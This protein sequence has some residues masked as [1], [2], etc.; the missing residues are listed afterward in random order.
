MRVIDRPLYMKKVLPMIDTEFIKIITGVRRSGKS[1]LL[2][3]IR[4]ELL[5]RSVNPKQIIYINFEN[6]EFF[7]LLN[8][9]DLYQ[10][11]KGKVNK[12]QKVYFLFDEIQE[13]TGWQ[14][15]VNGLRVAYDSDIY[16]TGSNASILSGELATYLTGRYVEI[17]VQPLTF[18]EYLHFKGKEKDHAERYFDDYLEYGGFPAVA[19]QTNDQ[20]KNDALNGI[21]NSILLRDVTQRT[22]VKNPE[23]LERI[24]LF[25]L[26]NIGQLVNVNKIANTLRSSGLRV[27]NNTIENYM[28]LLEDA[29]LFYKVSRYDIRG[30]EYLRGQ[31]KYY[32]VD[33]GFFRSQLRQ[34]GTN[35]GAMI[36]NL[37]FLKLLSDGYD[38][39]VGKY[40]TKEID[41][42]ATNEDQTL[43]IQV[44]DHIPEESNRETENLLHL[45]TGYQKILITNSWND[46]GNIDGIPV[47]HLLDFLL[48]PRG[49]WGNH[50]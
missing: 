39:F 48:A 21:F 22:T 23:V 28:K 46:V 29:F 26:A 6:P 50:I 18:E 38:V 44:N 15:L 43:Y 5:K 35:R 42:V 20:L 45:P 10:Y 32:V 36:E 25:L 49:K 24:A 14:K 4:N 16:I 7:D 13:V 33:L 11:L 8:Y 27:S 34:Q 40:D 9:K 3:M 47:V 1:Y 30:K 2:L 31:G 19:L 37:V 41:F 12:N 17:K